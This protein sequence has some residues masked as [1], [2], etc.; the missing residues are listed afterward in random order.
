MLLR[1]DAEMTEGQQHRANQD[2]QHADTDMKNSYDLRQHNHPDG[3]IYHL[4]R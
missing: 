2:R 4:A 1:H 3:T